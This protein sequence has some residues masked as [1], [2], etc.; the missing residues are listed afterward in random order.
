MRFFRVSTAEG[1]RW[2]RELS[3][4]TCV[5]L[6][7]APWRTPKELGEVKRA[8]LTLLAPAEP[9]KLVCIGRNYRAHAAELGNAVPKEPLIFLKPPSALAAPDQAIELPPE[10][11]RVEH[12]GELTLV[13]GKRLR[14]AKSEEE[15]RDAVFAITIANDVTAR[16]LQRADV[17]FTRAKSF[18]TFCPLGPSLVT[19][20]DPNDLALEVR[21]DGELRQHARTSA[22]VFRPF[23]LVAYVSRIMTL[24]PGDLLLTGTPEGVAPLTPGQTV[25]V[26]LEGVGT[27]SSP[28]VARKRGSA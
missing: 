14:D 15:A 6:D 4:D 11:E 16:D 28:V 8:G 3:D 21:V 23:E 18:D 24:E 5:L 20:L 13:I 7:D 1:P 19:D 9:T 12:E 10:S 26:S 22:M 17:Q 27:L 2:A 25:T